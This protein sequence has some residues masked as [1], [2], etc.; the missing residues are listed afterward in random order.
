MLAMQTNYPPSLPPENE[1]TASSVTPTAQNRSAPPPTPGV[2]PN[3]ST[4]RYPPTTSTSVPFSGQSALDTPFNRVPPSQVNDSSNSLNEVLHRSLMASSFASSNDL[5][6]QTIPRAHSN[7]KPFDL[8]ALREAANRE[9]KLFEQNTLPERK[10]GSMGGYD[11]PFH[12]PPTHSTQWPNHQDGNQSAQAVPETGSSAS[13]T[14]L[15]SFSPNVGMLPYANSGSSKELDYFLAANAARALAN[16]LG[17]GNSQ[18]SYSNNVGQPSDDRAKSPSMGFRDIMNSNIPPQQQPSSME[19]LYAHQ[20]DRSSPT[21]S[22]FGLP[23]LGMSGGAPPNMS[24]PFNSSPLPFSVPPHFR[25]NNP[26]YPS[27]PPHH[28]LPPNPFGGLDPGFADRMKDYSNPHH[29]IDSRYSTGG[30]MSRLP[31]SAS[32]MDGDVRGGGMIGDS[33]MSDASPNSSSS[34]KFISPHGQPSG[35]SGNGGN[36]VLYPWMNPKS[37]ELGIEN[38]RTRQTYTRYQTLELEK[39]FHFNKYLTRRRRIEIAHSL[40]LTERQIKIWFQNR[41]M[42][43]KKEHNIAKLNGPGTLE[44][45]EMMEQA[46]NASASSV[47]RSQPLYL[48]SP[49]HKPRGSHHFDS[50]SRSVETPS[51]SGAPSQAISDVP[52]YQRPD[53]PINCHSLVNSS[54]EGEEFNESACGEVY[55]MRQVKKFKHPSGSPLDLHPQDYPQSKLPP[56]HPYQSGNPSEPYG[57]REAEKPM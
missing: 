49:S 41:R 56:P 54:N 17:G 21:R 34:G 22:S 30:P 19:P 25:Q 53:V 37:C 6:D 13:N 7:G 20:R 10:D 2:T 44:Q 46:A 55:D 27:H 9:K 24:V 18:S 39:E 32:P 38:K 8:N 23:S 40:S 14:K 35:A 1:S 28:L 26:N 52:V 5:S 15:G 16:H 4:P 12:M 50:D 36:I 51:D 11:F 42:K 3:S 33:A 47:D 48:G 45:L 57:Q 43:W 31:R 29:L